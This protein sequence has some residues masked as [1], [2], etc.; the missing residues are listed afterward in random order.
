MVFFYVFWTVQSSNISLVKV[1]SHL[2]S[3]LSALLEI[4]LSHFINM[5]AAK[6]CC[7][8][9]LYL[10]LVL[11][12]SSVMVWSTFNDQYLIFFYICFAVDPTAVPWRSLAWPRWHACCWPARSSPHTWC[13]TKSSRST[14][15]GRTLR[16][17]ANRWL[18]YLKVENDYVKFLIVRQSEESIAEKGSEDVIWKS[19][20][21]L[22]F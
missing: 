19:V 6:I 14:T 20:F 22:F 16:G 10:F 3:T 4:P 1:S 5:W 13:L 9:F 17:W 15:W 2:P 11:F 12:F 21:C 8:F 18:A 7:V